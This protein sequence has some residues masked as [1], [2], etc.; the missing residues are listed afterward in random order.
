MIFDQVIIFHKCLESFRAESKKARGTETGGPL[1]GYV[2][3][4]NVLIAVDAAGPG[5]RAIL[6]RYSVTI[7]GEYAQRFCDIASNMSDGH[8]DYVGDWHRHTGISLKPSPLD[9]YAMKIMA[10]FSYSPTHF[11]V[12]L[13]YR[14]WPE[15]LVL[16]V[17]DGS[18]TLRRIPQS[19]VLLVD[20]FVRCH[21]PP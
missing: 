20:S 5:P 16:Y 13:I 12:S 18:G 3:A 1:V 8:I 17:W 6:K 19:K 10:E 9:I 2:T 11:P 15:A 4:E 7:D 14:K 21:E